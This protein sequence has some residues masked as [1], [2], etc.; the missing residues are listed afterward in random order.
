MFQISLGSQNP[1]QV[2]Y[3]TRQINR[4]FI[5]TWRE[6]WESICWNT[7][8]TPFIDHLSESLVLT[9]NSAPICQLYT[10]VYK[11]SQCSCFRSRT[12]LYQMT[13]LPYSSL[14]I[15]R[16]CQGT[17]IITIIITLFKSLIVLA[18]HE[19]STNWGDCKPNKSNH[20]NQIKSHH[21]K[22]NVGF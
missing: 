13:S 4:K 9:K 20:I 17:V 21:I 2:S 1:Y 10:K 3:M 18:E 5:I 22:L 15:V 8:L 7:L 14:K 12:V 19:C 6:Q 11:T 16:T